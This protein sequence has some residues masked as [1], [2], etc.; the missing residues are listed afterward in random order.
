MKKL[1]S[2]VSAG[3][4]LA[5]CCGGNSGWFASPEAWYDAG[6]EINPDYVDVVYFVSTEVL[7]SRNPDGSPSFRALLTEA[8]RDPITREMAHMQ[9]KVF[10]DSLNFFSPY[11]HQATMECFLLSPEERSSLVSEVGKEASEAF[12]YY[13][14]NLNGG[15]RF[16][17]AGFSQGGMLLKSV[18][19][20][21]SAEQFSR[22]VGAYFIGEQITAEDLRNPRFVPATGALDKGVVISFNSVVAP[23]DKWDVVCSEPACCINPVNWCTDSTPAT[24]RDGDFVLTATVDPEVNVVLVSGYGEDIPSPGWDAPWPKGC[25]HGKD[26]VAYDEFLG[27]NAKD[28]AYR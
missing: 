7:E 23:E 19:R 22:M 3:F 27:Q 18:I 12:A 28:R 24:F 11:Y 15:R 14:K 2:L 8:E 9:K 17:L 16:I 10:N 21:M 13:M 1:F 26:I 6:V 20:K 4:L 25:L 5:S